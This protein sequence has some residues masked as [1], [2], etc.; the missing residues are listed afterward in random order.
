MQLRK[1]EKKIQ[2]QKMKLRVYEDDV[3]K[4]TDSICKED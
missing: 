1:K 3:Q 4:S 2:F